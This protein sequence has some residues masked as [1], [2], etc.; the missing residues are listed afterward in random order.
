MKTTS[1]QVSGNKDFK[2]LHEKYETSMNLDELGDV[3]WCNV[4][5]RDATCILC[6]ALPSFAK[7]HRKERGSD[8][9]K[10]LQKNVVERCSTLKNT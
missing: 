10:L 6:Q 2:T 5:Q 3:D 9:P 4:M 7:L 8:H 1:S